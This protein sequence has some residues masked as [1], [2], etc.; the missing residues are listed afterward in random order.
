MQGC[1][2]LNSLRHLKI[3]GAK[4]LIRRNFPNEDAKITGH[5]R[6]IYLAV[7]VCKVCIL[8]VRKICCTFVVDDWDCNR[9]QAWRTL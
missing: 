4:I 3:L 9:E 8:I 5:Q 1:P 6:K 2:I 7:G